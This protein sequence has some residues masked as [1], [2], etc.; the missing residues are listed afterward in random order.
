[1][2]RTEPSKALTVACWRRCKTLHLCM[3][4]LCEWKHRGMCRAGAGVA[5]DGGAA[6]ELPGAAGGG[7]ACGAQRAAGAAGAGARALQSA[8]HQPGAHSRGCARCRQQQPFNTDQIKLY[9]KTVQRLCSTFRAC[10]LHIA[11]VEQACMRH[12][13]SVTRSCCISHAGVVQGCDG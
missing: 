10:L 5:A 13:W 2:C 6:V 12:R 4:R 3:V 9:S 1:M 7:A 11:H 8:A